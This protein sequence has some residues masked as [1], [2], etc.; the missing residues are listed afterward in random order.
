MEFVN[1]S[2]YT[3]IDVESNDNTPMMAQ[4]VYRN[5]GL[6]FAVTHVRLYEGEPEGKLCA[7]TGWS[8]ADGGTETKAYAV[9]IEDSSEG[10]A[11]LVYGG[12]WGVRLRPAESEAA[13]S[14]E[15]FDQWGETHLVIADEA[16]LTRG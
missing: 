16:D 7:I 1:A 6:P 8:S 14:L 12:D 15:D 11:Y 9:K 4:Q 2:G 10:M 5:I 13:W 3:H